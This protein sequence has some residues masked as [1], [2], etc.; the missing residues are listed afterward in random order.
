MSGR[1]NTRESRRPAR[2]PILWVRR[3]AGGAA[4]IAGAVVAASLL[5]V[6]A[7]VA[8]G[9]RPMVEQ[10]DSMAPMLRAGDVLF[11]KETSAA[12]AE[13][14]DVITFA[15]SEHPGRTITHRVESVAQTDRGALAFVTRGD[16][17][18]GVERWQARP[19]AAI[20]RYVFRI[21]KAGYLVEHT[22][23]GVWRVLVVIAALSVCAG[24]LTRIW[25]TPPASGLCTNVGR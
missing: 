13:K 22:R 24:A 19:G 4:T 25:R 18:T 2:P 23:N 14:G 6:G 21:P 11:V 9:H 16:A 15:D 5:A 20:G 12:D 17:N 7:L 1:S 8:S 3:L 10:S